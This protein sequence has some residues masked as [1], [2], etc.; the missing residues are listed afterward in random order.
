MEDYYV[1]ITTRRIK[2]GTREEFERSWEPADFPEGL[3]RADAWWNE[4][5]D[6]IVGVSFWESQEPCQRYRASDVEA[7]RRE[8]MGPYVVEESSKTYW[9]RELK[10]PG[11]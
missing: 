11:R 9:G 7:R 8:A 2:P 6:E 5:G 3:F 1:W 10:I 4:E